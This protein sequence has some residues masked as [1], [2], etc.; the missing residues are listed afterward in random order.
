[1]RTSCLRDY[2]NIPSLMT[3]ILRSLPSMSYKICNNLLSIRISAITFLI[4]L[5]NLM[6]TMTTTMTMTMTMTTM[7]VETLRKAQLLHR[8]QHPWKHLL[9]DHL[10]QFLKTHQSLYLT[11]GRLAVYQSLYL[12]WVY[13][14]SLLACQ[15]LIIVVYEISYGCLSPILR[16]QS[17]LSLSVH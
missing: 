12:L 5:V 16:S 8:P 14:V 6:M 7:V 3:M 10:P 9:V 17:S 4:Q 1:M 13:G 11:L 2:R 15:E